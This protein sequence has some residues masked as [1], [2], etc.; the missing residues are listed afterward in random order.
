MVSHDAYLRVTGETLQNLDNTAEH[1]RRVLCGLLA[2]DIDYGEEG[3]KILS[4]GVND[5]RL[6]KSKEEIDNL[7]W[8]Y[9]AFLGKAII[10]SFS[11]GKNHW[12]DNKVDNYCIK[13]YTNAG[14][15]TMV[16]PFTRVIKHFEDGEVSSMYAFFKK[17]EFVVENGMKNLARK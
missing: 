14:E 1:I 6:K 9:G 8:M 16:A 17:V 3:V 11:G 2:R 5:L 10:E 15:E 7:I 13:V 4:D 12:A